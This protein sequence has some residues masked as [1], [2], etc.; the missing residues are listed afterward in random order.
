MVTFQEHMA[1]DT[2][3]IFGSVAGESELITYD[4]VEIS[5]FV[6]YGADLR[7][8]PGYRGVVAEMVIRVRRSDLT[9]TAKGTEVIVNQE[10]WQVAR[11]SGGDGIVVTI[12]LEAAKAP[13]P[14][15]S[16]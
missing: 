7:T 6:E 11:C 13:I 15:R 3:A 9:T 12:E 10:S 2:A 5:A 4:G 16:L 1:A 8:L 14:R